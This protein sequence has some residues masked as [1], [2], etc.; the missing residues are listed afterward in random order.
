M[1]DQLSPEQVQQISD[2]LAA[3]RKIEAIKIC[4]GATGKDLKEAKEFIDALIPRLKEEDPEKYAALSSS[5]SGCG[6]A[7]LMCFCLL[8]ALGIF[9]MLSRV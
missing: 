7:V 2:A 3:G 9:A 8:S 1:S 5:G 4:R 6:T